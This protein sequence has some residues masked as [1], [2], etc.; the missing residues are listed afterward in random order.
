[1]FD[2]AALLKKYITLELIICQFIHDNDYQKYHTKE[3]AT[4]T[5]MNNLKTAN[6]N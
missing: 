3:I 4:V 6:F 1:M 5:R 2:F